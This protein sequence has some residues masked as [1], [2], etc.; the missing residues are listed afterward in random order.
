MRTA[1]RYFLLILVPLAATLVNAGCTPF[2]RS[3]DSA[4]RYE[5]PTLR[6]AA[7]PDDGD[8]Q[9]ASFEDDL[10]IAK[11]K[12]DRF[13][14]NKSVKELTG[15]GADRKVAQQYYRAGDM[16]YREAI[17]ADEKRRGKLFD[18]AAQ[19]FEQSAD[20]WPDSSLEQDSLFMAGES[21]F[22]ADH[23]SDAN[24]KYELLL[25]KYP[26]TKHLD[27]V[28]AK[29]FSIARYWLEY[30]KVKPQSFFSYNFTD[31][32]RPL[33]DT[34]GNSVRVFD[35]IRLD[36]PTGK[37]ADDATLAAANAHFERG[38][39][40]RAS[41]FYE[42]LRRT[43]PSS[44]HQFV[45]HFLGMKSKLESYQGPRYAGD[46]LLDAE[47]LLRQ[48]LRQFPRDAEQHREELQRAAR[49]IHY[50]KAERE[51]QI[52]RYY[53][54]RGEYRAAR[55]YYNTLASEYSDTKFGETALARLPEIGGKPDIPPQKLS[56][57]VSIFPQ[58]DTVK[59]LIATGETSTKLR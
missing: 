29:R 23:Y 3:I 4:F 24:K 1:V 7:E 54:Q 19:L 41:E 10:L 32:R 15:H 55:M 28:E 30:N 2:R 39:F 26:N 31:E 59:P 42:D 14:L 44:E 43:F 48:I 33:R 11:K 45:A 57:L 20:R 18:E 22:F 8:V 21:Y 25:K 37:L 35:K 17:A 58:R 36:D 52:A 51:E 49:E 6:A 16:K 50:R 13:N 27:K 47:E 53:D 56:W 38:N 40:I 5:D 46:A 34:F 12:D 9:L